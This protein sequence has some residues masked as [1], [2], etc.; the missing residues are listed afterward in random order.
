MGLFNR[1][2]SSEPKPEHSIGLMYVFERGKDDIAY[3]TAICDCGW[4]VEPVDAEYPN[5]AL[6][7]QIR[8]QARAHHP[9][10]DAEIAFPLDK[11][12]T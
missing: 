4:F 5:P 12:R 7:E 10:V 1:L 11:P 3:Y 9:D 2:F 8:M 6:E